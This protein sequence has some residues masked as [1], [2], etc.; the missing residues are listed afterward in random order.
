MNK[1]IASTSIL[2]LLGAAASSCTKELDFVYHDIEPVLV[3]EAELTQSGIGVELTETTPMDEAFSGLR[4]TDATVGM[5]DLTEGSTIVLQPDADGRYTAPG[6]GV[7]GHEYMLTIERQGKKYSSGCTMAAPCEILAMGFGW[8]KMPYDRVAVLQVSFTDPPE[9]AG[10][11]YWLRIYR[12]GTTYKWSPVT[13][14][15]ASD[16][17]INVTMM[18]S[19]LDDI[20]NPEETEEL[21]DGDIISARLTPVSRSMYDYLVAIGAD[22]SGP[23][24]FSGDSCLGYFLAA[25]V[26]ET[27]IV[28]RP[29]EIPFD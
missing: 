9:S 24:M 3:V 11:C 23:A 21:K 14:A 8:I 13:D 18:T 22:S 6:G 29:S 15:S 26:A 16:G 10:D 20:E 25:P 17:V 28:F 4:L 7:S 27:T 5:T 12:N 19:R 2:L 1:A